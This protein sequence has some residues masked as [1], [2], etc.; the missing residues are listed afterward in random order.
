METEPK[1]LSIYKYKEAM[2]KTYEIIR[3][4]AMKHPFPIGSYPKD[5]EEYFQY[6]MNAALLAFMTLAELDDG[7]W[8]EN[9]QKLDN[10]WNSLL[11]EGLKMIKDIQG[12]IFALKFFVSFHFWLLCFQPRADG[13]SARNFIFIQHSQFFQAIFVYSAN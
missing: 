6:N 1:G 5:K 9:Y 10:Y 12:E 13:R 3:N 4:E 2:K 11:M 7:L 8:Y